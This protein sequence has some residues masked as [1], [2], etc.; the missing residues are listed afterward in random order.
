M[1]GRGG[2][3]LRIFSGVVAGD[4]T[5]FSGR[6]FLG[7]G[8]Y[9]LDHVSGSSYSFQLPYWFLI[10]VT[11]V[12]PLLMLKAFIRNRQRDHRLALNLCPTCGYDLRATPDRCPECGTVPAS[13][14]A[15]DPS[16]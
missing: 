14:I 13:N 16:A 7:F 10:V 5:S 1:S 2:L 15:R 9:H 4:V 6:F 11:A 3:I 12:L 8:S